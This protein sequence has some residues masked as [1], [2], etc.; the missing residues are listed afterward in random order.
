MLPDGNSAHT[1]GAVLA[2]SDLVRNALF[3]K[4]KISL[5]HHFTS[6]HSLVLDIY[7]CKNI[8]LRAK[9][10]LTAQNTTKCSGFTTICSG[11]STESGYYALY[12]CGVKQI[13]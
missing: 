6:G 5:A 4:Y 7:I 12:L 3:A 9:P 10:G 11:F 8:A 1:A 13:K 2:K